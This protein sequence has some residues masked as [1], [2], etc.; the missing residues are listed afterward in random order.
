MIEPVAS[1]ITQRRSEITSGT[2]SLNIYGKKKKIYTY[3]YVFHLYY[4]IN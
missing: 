3:V 1:Y 4:Y 2:F